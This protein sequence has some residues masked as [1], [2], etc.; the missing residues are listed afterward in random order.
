M[1][2]IINTLNV[3]IKIQFLIS[4]HNVNVKWLWRLIQLTANKTDALSRDMDKYSQKHEY[5]RKLST[6]VMINQL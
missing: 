6:Y 4:M 1:K 5:I 3:L 2:Y